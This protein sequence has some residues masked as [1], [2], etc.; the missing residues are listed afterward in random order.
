MAAIRGPVIYKHGHCLFWV[1]DP[2]GHQFAM[3]Q[4]LPE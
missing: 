1:T 2:D 4:L 3:L